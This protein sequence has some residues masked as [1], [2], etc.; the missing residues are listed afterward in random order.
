[1]Q[2]IL[3]KLSKYLEKITS[4]GKNKDL[5]LIG[6]PSTNLNLPNTSIYDVEIKKVKVKNITIKENE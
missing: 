3:Q 4:H 1:M 2:N 5:P 6:C